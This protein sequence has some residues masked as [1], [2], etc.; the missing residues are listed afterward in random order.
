M[1]NSHRDIFSVLQIVA[2][3]IFFMTMDLCH[4]ITAYTPTLYRTFPR[5]LYSIPGR[6]DHPFLQPT[7]Q[8]RFLNLQKNTS[9]D[10]DTSSSSSAATTTTTTNTNLEYLKEQLSLYL[11]KRQA[12]QADLI[13]KDQVGKVIGGT[14]GNAILEFISGS[15]N[16]P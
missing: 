13:A 16:K 7:A 11:E 3:Y 1:L 12:V 5:H 6:F 2:A 4:T 10:D 15:P 14:I 8:Q 9:E